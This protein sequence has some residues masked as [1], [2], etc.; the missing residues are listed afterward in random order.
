M[1]KELLKEIILENQNFVLKKQFLERPFVFEEKGNYVLLGLR[2]SGKSYLMYQRI[3]A[4]LKVGHSI[5]EIVYIN[6]EDDRLL[7]LT[8]DDLNT[9]KLC[10]E[11][12]FHHTPVFFLDEIQI[13]QGWEKF[14]RRLADKDYRVFVTGSNAEMLSS[15]IATT[16]GG[17]FLI[18]EVYPF[19]FEEYLSA[20]DISLEKN[21]KYL[22]EVRSSVVR[23]FDTYF[24]FGGLPELLQFND[25]RSWLSSLYQKIFFGDLVARYNIRNSN[26]L[27]LVIKKLAESVKQPTSYNRLANVVS[28]AGVRVGIQ[29]VIDYLGYLEET[30]LLFSVENYAAKFSEKESVKKYYFRDNG[31]LNLFLFDP[32]TSLLENLVGIH[33]KKRFGEQ[34]YYYNRNIEVDFLL[35]EQSMAIQVSYNLSDADTLKREV[36]GLLKLAGQLPIQQMLIITRDESRI[37]EQDGHTIQVIPIWEWLLSFRCPAI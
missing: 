10:Y 21:W 33:L 20:Q 18:Q 13:I 14:V 36:N 9:I 1:N 24:Y 26:G 2:R 8:L 16:L 32:E 25:K 31:I 7:E 12:L 35:P 30:W 23:T 27:R 3:H 19:S 11:E 22:S 17:R 28:S 15:E 34:V 4:Y 29:T 37:I 6:F 5:E